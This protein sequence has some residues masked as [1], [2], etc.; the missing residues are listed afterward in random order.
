LTAIT[1]PLAIAHPD[2]VR[3][4]VENGFQLPVQLPIRLQ[5]PGRSFENAQFLKIADRAD[6]L[7]MPQDRRHVQNDF[8]FFAGHLMPENRPARFQALVDN[9][10]RK[11][12]YIQYGSTRMPAS[13]DTEKFLG[14]TV[15]VRN[16][17]VYI[18]DNDTVTSILKNIVE[19]YFC[20]HKAFAL[21]F[22]KIDS[23]QTEKT[24]LKSL[25]KKIKDRNLLF[26]QSSMPKA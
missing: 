9:A 25:D 6:D 15:D 11:G 1:T 16:H 19:I 4:G 2:A 21:Q 5:V 17:T 7:A 18:G 8:G 3:G 23:L 13:I 20:F 14:T 22:G 10:A 24:I 26:T 12:Q